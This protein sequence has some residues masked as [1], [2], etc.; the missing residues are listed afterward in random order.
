[1]LSGMLYV[2][3][4]RGM[5][6][7]GVVAAIRH[8]TGIR[9]IGHT[10]T[11][12]PEASGV[13]IL[14]LGRATKLAQLFEDLDKT[15]WTVL[16]LGICTDTQDATGAVVRQCAVPALSGTAVQ[17]ILAQFTGPVKQIPPMYSAVKYHG[18]RL[19]RLARQG[20]T[21]VRSARNI[22]IR[23]LELLDLRGPWMTLSV[24]CSKGT[25]IRTL[26][27]DIGRAIGC[28]AHMVHLQRCRVGTI[29]LQRTLSL[30]WL[31]QRSYAGTWESL[32]V[33]AAQAFE[34][35]PAL[36][37]TPQ[38]YED[39]QVRQSGALAAI[40]S[41]IPQQGALGPCYRLCTPW[42]STIAI[43]QRQASSPERWKLYNLPAHV[44]VS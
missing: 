20:K 28:G 31:R 10:G 17:S 33:P 40:L 8:L 4:P 19:Y 43:I 30:E 32:L 34:F 14:C 35:L 6:S 11:L 41:P 23:R 15:Y 12:D 2:D 5:T 9:A 27:E 13:L 3:K 1:M 22:C 21:V 24:T 38:Q 7:H 42:H 26:C 37:L 16:C 44:P 25:Y 18:Q 36:Q 29:D 39:F